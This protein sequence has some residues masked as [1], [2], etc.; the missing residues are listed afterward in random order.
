VTLLSALAENL[1][2]VHNELE[3]II[4]FKKSGLIKNVAKEG[5]EKK[6]LPRPM[7][8]ESEVYEMVRGKL[9]TSIFSLTDAIGA[10]NK[11]Q[12]LKLL[13]EQIESGAAETYL[14][15]M[16]LR[17]FKIILRIRAA[18]DLGGNSRSMSASLKLH[19]FIVQKGVGQA[20]F[21]SLGS[22]KKILSRLVRMDYE[23]K[24]GQGDLKT[25]LSLL[26]AELK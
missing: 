14:L 11:A 23:L 4:A 9:D 6:N 7:I 19:P 24:T 2:Q 17:Q 8:E 10:R 12:A 21:F 25:G 3:K 13:E 20:R 22:L 15:S 16:I 1:W 18:L 26:I 5:S